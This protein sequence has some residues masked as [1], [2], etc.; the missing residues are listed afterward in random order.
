MGLDDGLEHT[1]VS[2]FPCFMWNGVTRHPKPPADTRE[3][4]KICQRL[5]D[6]KKAPAIMAWMQMIQS[7]RSLLRTTQP[8]ST[9]NLPR[10]YSK[11]PPYAGNRFFLPDFVYLI[12]A[13][14]DLIVRVLMWICVLDWIFVCS[15]GWDPRVLEW[16]WGRSRGSYCQTRN[17]DRWSFETACDSYPQAQEAWRPLQTCKYH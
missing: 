12:R 17:W 10:F 14:I 1:I 3:E 16:D 9:L 4:E 8:S 11:P 13:R 6:W 15:E 5:T 2:I 7:A